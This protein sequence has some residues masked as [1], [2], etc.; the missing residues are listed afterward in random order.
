MHTEIIGSV[1]NPRLL[2]SNQ[3][4][5][6][7]DFFDGNL[8][9]QHASHYGGNWNSGAPGKARAATAS[10]D[11]DDGITGGCN[12]QQHNP[13]SLASNRK[14]YKEG[15]SACSQCNED[16]AQT[17][18]GRIPTAIS[19]TGF[20]RKARPPATHTLSLPS[21]T[22]SS[23]RR[24]SGNLPTRNSNDHEITQNANQANF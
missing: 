4:K 1:A 7:P 9:G 3:K 5:V 12:P 6:S 22:M 14:S 19:P 23:R 18:G 21:R 10:A 20:T 2:L 17:I 16:A 24:K 8:A 11:G 15:H 13:E